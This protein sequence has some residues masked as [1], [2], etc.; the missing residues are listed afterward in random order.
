MDRPASFSTALAIY[1]TLGTPEAEQVRTQLDVIGNGIGCKLHTW[2]DP[3]GG[4]GTT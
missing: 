4:L 1:D 3:I 2:K